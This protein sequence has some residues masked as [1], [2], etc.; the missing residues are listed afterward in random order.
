MRN[1]EKA[2]SKR[3]AESTRS[4][5][6][7]PQKAK[8]KRKSRPTRLYKKSF[9]T[10]RRRHV[11][12]RMFSEGKVV[13]EKENRDVPPQTRHGCAFFIHNKRNDRYNA[14]NKGEATGGD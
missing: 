1:K 12:R 8:A 3:N 7:L 11:N 2:K 4:L 5:L 13:D 10:S 14:M 6:L 9:L